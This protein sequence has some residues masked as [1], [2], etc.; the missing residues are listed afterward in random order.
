MAWVDKLE[1]FT[2]YTTCHPLLST[3]TAWLWRP[4][5]MTSSYRWA[6]SRNPPCSGKS[7]SLT[8][9]IKA[10]LFRCDSV[11]FFIFKYWHR[12]Q[13]VFLDFMSQMQCP[14]FLR[15]GRG[16]NSTKKVNVIIMAGDC[17][18]FSSSP[19][20]PQGFWLQLVSSFCGWSVM[21][22]IVLQVITVERKLLIVWLQMYSIKQ[23]LCVAKYIQITEWAVSIKD[24]P[25]K[26]WSVLTIITVLSSLHMTLNGL[27]FLMV[28]ANIILEWL[29]W[30]RHI[31]VLMSRSTVFCQR[32][33]LK[34]HTSGF[35]GLIHVTI[36]TLCVAANH[37][38]NCAV[39]F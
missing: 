2:M 23:A 8:S 14:F 11:S 26:Y 16:E 25:D 3:Q 30:F 36:V 32:D 12:R 24:W 4:K 39:S 21:C 18:P 17:K 15:M 19:N 1:S 35:A 6:V 7:S 5:A 28:I 38:A 20:Q 27:C 37:F 13:V 10:M 33:T 22:C 9:D 31:F 29:E 34:H